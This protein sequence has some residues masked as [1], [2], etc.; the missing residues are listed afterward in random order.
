[1]KTAYHGVFAQQNTP[2]LTLF[3]MKPAVSRSESAKPISKGNGPLSGF[4]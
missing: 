4:E 1:M 2:K 3:G